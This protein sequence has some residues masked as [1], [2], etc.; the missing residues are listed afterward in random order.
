[1]ETGSTVKLK[2]GGPVI[3]VEY[4]DYKIVGCHWFEGKILQKGK[5]WAKELDMYEM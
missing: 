4:V 2:S 3:T 1:M 5:F